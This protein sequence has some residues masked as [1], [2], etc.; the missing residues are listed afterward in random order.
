M[1]NEEL[2]NRIVLHIY[3]AFSMLVSVIMAAGNAP[4]GAALFWLLGAYI[5]AHIG[6]DRLTRTWNAT[7]GRL[8]RLHVEPLDG[9][10]SA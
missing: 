7:L 3:F 9:G 8:P 10:E 2:Y 1:D 6:T 5:G 4:I